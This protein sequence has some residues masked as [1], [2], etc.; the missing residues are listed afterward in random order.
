M[1]PADSIA[2]FV[3]ENCITALFLERKITFLNDF[4]SVQPSLSA[5]GESLSMPGRSA[6]A[7]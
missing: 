1:V 2:L 4:H 3:I 6:F 7:R 5:P